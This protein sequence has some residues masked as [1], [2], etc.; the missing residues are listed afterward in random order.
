VPAPDSLAALRNPLF[1][2]FALGRIVSVLGAQ[3]VSLAVG[4]QLYERTGSAF[5]LGAVGLVELVPVLFLALPAGHLAD[6][7]SRRDVAIFAHAVLA[8][9]SL[10]LALVAVLHG[11]IAAIYALLFC[12]GVGVAFRSPSVGAI[13]PQ[14]LPPGQFNTANAWLSSGN[15]LATIAGPALGGFAIALTSG[16]TWAYGLA[17]G[18]HLIFIALLSTLPRNEPAR[19][20]PGGGRSLRQQARPSWP[21][22][23]AGL[24]FV[25]RTRLFL[26][27]I[28][29]DLFAVLLGGATALLPIFAKDILHTGA[30]GLGLLRAAPALGAL[31]MALVQTRLA[32]WKR[33]G[34]V[35]LWTVAGF[36][37]ATVVFGLSR[38]F[39][40]SFAMLALTGLFDNIS[41]VIRLTL[42]QLL[43]PDSM[44][45]R[46][47]AV[48][49]VFIGLS[50]ELG[51][52]ESGATAALVGPLASVVGGGLGTILVVALVAWN[53]PVLAALGPLGQ[54]DA[55]EAQP[56]PTAAP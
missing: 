32:P 5:A 52:F 10:G 29:L 27:A 1:R 18:T 28:T 54:M 12:T 47:S 49:H 46:V 13:L 9:S 45:G 22:L 8:L 20:N 36:G 34:V 44:R 55:A 31:A 17:C 41:V 7:F 21:D 14:L 24:H 6:R 4:F 37:A 56:E 35:L 2:R 39:A 42:E 40:L 33:P 53:W 48:H 19:L 50:N 38:N 3:M 11:P 43:T 51:S 15:E 23:L 25:L 30:V 16:E 26:A